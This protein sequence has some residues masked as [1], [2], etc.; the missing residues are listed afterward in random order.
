M[1][2]MLY[3]IKETKIFYYKNEIFP[4]SIKKK[5]INKNNKIARKFKS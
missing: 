1:T 3:G 4:A 5:E 2:D